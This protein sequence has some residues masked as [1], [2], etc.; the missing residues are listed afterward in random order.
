MKINL[1]GTKDKT[2]ESHWE[3]VSVLYTADMKGLASKEES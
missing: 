2:S 1:F 3:C